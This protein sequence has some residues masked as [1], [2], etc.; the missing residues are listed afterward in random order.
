[1]SLLDHFRM[2]VEDPPPVYAFEVAANGLAYAVRAPKRGQAPEMGFR[3]FAPDTLA[4]SPVRDNVARP[5]E[6]AAEVKAAVKL[7]GRRRDAAL[8]LP[9]YS[10]RIAVLDFD[11]F[12]TVKEEQTSLVRF[13]MKKTVPFDLDAAALNFH[14]QKSSSKKIEVVAAVALEE[15]VARYEAPFRA[16]GFTPGFVTTSVLAAM[17]LMPADG[18]N[19]LAKLGGRTLTVAVCEGRN[20]KLVRCLELSDASVG[21]VMSV[22][23]PT[24]AFAEDELGRRPQRLLCCGFGNGADEFRMT[25]EGDLQVPVE[26]LRSPLGPAAAHNA[27][28]LGWLAAQQEGI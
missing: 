15:I 10:T 2:L 23:F 5:E 22:V 6:F 18:L 21:E 17:D 26:P 9:D 24:F 28:L 13:R 27:G 1:M 4:V 12:P 25:V 16:A 3:E 7:N 19:A 20:P 11:S 8:I 14:V